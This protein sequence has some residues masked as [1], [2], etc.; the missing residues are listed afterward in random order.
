MVHC[1]GSCPAEGFRHDWGARRAEAN[2]QPARSGPLP[3]VLDPSHEAL[4]K[5]RRMEFCR[6][7]AF[8]VP[9][10]RAVGCSPRSRTRC[11]PAGQRWPRSTFSSCP[12]QTQQ[13]PTGPGLPALSPKSLCEWHLLVAAK[14]PLG[15]IK[16]CRADGK[17]RPG[18]RGRRLNASFLIPA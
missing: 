12:S 10:S 15:E 1:H 2:Y 17:D 7:E 18:Q 16:S 8:R 9:P 13:L 6:Q 11:L 5:T 4:R 14:T 3:T